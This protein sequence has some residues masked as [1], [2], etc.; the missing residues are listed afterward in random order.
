MPRIG[1]KKALERIN[2]YLSEIERL[3]KVGQVAGESEREDLNYKI[4]AFLNNAFD[5]PENK[6]REYDQY[7][8]AFFE[9]IGKEK[10]YKEKENEYQQNLREMETMLKSYREE[11]EMVNQNDIA[12]EEKS[13]DL[14]NIFIV[15]GH[16]KISKFELARI[17]ESEFD[18]KAILFDEQADMGKTIIEKLE[19]LAKLPG[20]AFVLLT[21]DDLGGENV[22]GLDLK[23]LDIAEIQLKDLKINLKY[24][25]RQNVVLELGYFIACLGRNRVC[26]LYK[27]GVEL[28]SD[29]SGFIYKEFTYSVREKESEIRKELRAVGYDV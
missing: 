7:V 3:K 25:A 21:P 28:P 10:T 29:I 13:Y 18:L 4:K 20:Y 16:D 19:G 11:L 12:A 26:C 22:Q 6:I 9:V 8:N 24:R 5:V 23:D 15:Y 14:K 1:P 17:I 2:G 27:T